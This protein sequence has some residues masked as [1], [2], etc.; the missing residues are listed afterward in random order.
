MPVRRE[1]LDAPALGFS[2]GQNDTPVGI[3]TPYLRRGVAAFRVG[4][5]GRKSKGFA[6]G[7]GKT[8]RHG[9]DFLDGVMNLMRQR[10]FCLQKTQTDEQHAM[11]AYFGKAVS[12]VGAPL[13][14]E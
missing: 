4:F 11:A 3:G 7:M 9:V 14:I 12:H 5:K 8:N 6:S 1:S 2:W 13:W 10:H